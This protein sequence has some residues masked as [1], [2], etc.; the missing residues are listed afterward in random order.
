MFN[1]IAALQIVILAVVILFAVPSFGMLEL[2]WRKQVAIREA[3]KGI[4]QG[5]RLGVIINLTADKALKV[6]PDMFEANK[7]QLKTR[8]AQIV[9]TVQHPEPSTRAYVLLKQSGLGEFLNDDTR[10]KVQNAAARLI[11]N[12]NLDGL[13]D[14]LWEV[15]DQL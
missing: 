3:M 9:K 1:T 2:I 4:V 13:R 6:S 15:V 12:G 5:Q 11:V 8:I 14:F 7:E 10:Q